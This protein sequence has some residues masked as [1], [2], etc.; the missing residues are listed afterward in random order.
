MFCI[1]HMIYIF[2]HISVKNARIIFKTFIFY[3]YGPTSISFLWVITIT[4]FHEPVPLRV[5]LSVFGL[6]AKRQICKAVPISVRRFGY[7]MASKHIV[8]ASK[9][10]GRMEGVHTR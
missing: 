5:L 9:I 7:A 3:F 8:T 10:P 4:V 6:H 1:L 2:Y